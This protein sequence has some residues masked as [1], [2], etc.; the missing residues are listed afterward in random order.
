MTYKL[1]LSG[2]IDNYYYNGKA[3][4]N[5]I[6]DVHLDYTFI[7]TSKLDEPDLLKIDTDFPTGDESS[8]EVLSEFV[9]DLYFYFFDF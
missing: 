5:S 1:E 3:C 7:Y 8:S 6:S 2:S 4:F 9:I